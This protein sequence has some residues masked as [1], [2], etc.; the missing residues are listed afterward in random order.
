MTAVTS[1]D[2][3]NQLDDC[4]II[5]CCVTVITRCRLSDAHMVLDDTKKKSATTLLA[6]ED[7]ILQLKDE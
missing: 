4:V 6:T 5:T 7:E 2:C 3:Y 1:C